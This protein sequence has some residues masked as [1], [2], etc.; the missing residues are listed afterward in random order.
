MGCIAPVFRSSPEYRVHAAIGLS[1]VCCIPTTI[2]TSIH[3]VLTATGL[4]LARYGM[5]IHLSW[6]TSSPTSMDAWLLFCGSSWYSTGQLRLG[7]Y[8]DGFDFPLFSKSI[9]APTLDFNPYG[10]LPRVGSVPPTVGWSTSG[11]FSEGFHLWTGSGPLVY[12]RAFT[13]FSWKLDIVTMSD[14]VY[15]SW[16]HSVGPSF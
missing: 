3:H 9:M 1:P 6:D 11:I 5:V 8:E 15:R 13:I 2:G 16:N 14:N 10:I 12:C 4:A 7:G